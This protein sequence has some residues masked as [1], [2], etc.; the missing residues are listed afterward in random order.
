MKK[1]L[2]KKVTSAVMAFVLEFEVLSIST[3]NNPLSGILSVDAATSSVTFDSKNGIL[4]LSGNV[5]NKDVQKWST[6]SNVKKVICDEGTVFPENCAK[7]FSYYWAEEIDLSNANTSN[8][9]D[10]DGMFWMCG[11][12]SLDLS[13]FD[14]SNVTTMSGMFQVCSAESLDVSSFNT[15]KVTDMKYMFEGCYN[16]KSLDLSRFDTSKVTD[17]K[18]MFDGCYNLKSIDLS[19]FDTSNVTTMKGMFQGCHAESLDVSSF[20]TSKVTD[21]SAM[22]DSCSIKS[23]NLSSFDTSNVIDMSDMFFSDSHLE[24]LDL[25]NFDTSNV[26]NMSDMFG[27][28]MSFETLDLSRF[29]TSNVTDMT[30]MFNGCYNLKSLDLS[31]F[32]TSNVTK[33]NKMFYEC[34]TLK[35]LDLTIFETS[36]VCDM[37]DMFGFCSSLEKIFVSD[38]WTVS[39]VTSSNLMFAECSKLVGGN[40][41]E[42]I[43]AYSNKDRA[44]VDTP[45]T[46][47]YL[48]MVNKLKG[49]SLTLDGN[50]GLNI[51][52]YINNSTEKVILSGPVGDVVITDLLKK[53][54]DGTNKF[55]YK[56]NAVQARENIT[57][58]FYDKY[59][60]ILRI[61]KMNE[62]DEIVQKLDYSVQDYLADIKD[63]DLYK[64][65]VKLKYIIDATEN[66][67]NAAENYFNG[68]N[69]TIRYISDVNKKSVEEYAPEYDN[70]IKLSLVLNSETAMRI[71][72]DANKVEYGSNVISPKTGKYGKYYEISN[73]P[74]HKLGSEFNVIIDGKKYKFIPLSYVY[75]AL[76]NTSNKLIDIAKATY[77]YAKAAEA[78][79]A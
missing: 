5:V 71:Y 70:K 49:A 34:V 54:I 50:I 4:T 22:F 55:T 79:V 52:A 16:L 53:E 74:A 28:C 78:Y 56:I 42:Y 60:N 62:D 69:N 20:N 61:C 68:T 2:I 31:S 13:S 33:M 19:S 6:N 30:Y 21:M 59:G 65:N 72:T 73:I 29:D 17:M 25:S 3:G 18:Y 15:S 36:N 63:E 67:C 46:P 11:A 26:C 44:V 38:K 7:M 76:D 1:H 39:S 9:T 64:T 58:K 37:S 75:R 43:A 23:L 10:M 48:T 77:V 57:L 51:Y 32:D 12:S 35:S 40:G 24:S 14:T 45:E 27:F 41:T 47:G 8:V 66:Y